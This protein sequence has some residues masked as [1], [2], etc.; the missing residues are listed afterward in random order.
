MTDSNEP[1]E[2]RVLTS[3]RQL[4]PGEAF[5]VRRPEDE[6]EEHGTVVVMPHGCPPTAWNIVNF[7][8]ADGTDATLAW[9]VETDG[10]LRNEEGIGLDRVVFGVGVVGR[11]F[12]KG[13]P[14]FVQGECM[15]CDKTFLKPFV[16]AKDKV[17]LA[18]R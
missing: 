16:W 17:I 13:V 18:P 1:A 11:T 7:D 15:A 2:V 6:R 12:P 5:P 8:P 4:Q 9:A 14:F 10:K 3:G